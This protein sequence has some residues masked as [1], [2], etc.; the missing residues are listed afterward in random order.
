VAKQFA[1]TAPE[2]LGRAVSIWSTPPHIFK[3]L[4]AEFHF[5][6]DVCADQENKKCKHW[7]H[8]V[9]CLRRT[10]IGTCWLNPPYGKEISEYLGKAKESAVAGATVVCLVPG[11]TNAPWWH[12]HVMRAAEIRFVRKK[13]AFI[14]DDG[15]EGVP[16]WGTVIAIFRP[17]DYSGAM[18]KVCSWEQPTKH[19]NRA[20]R[21]PRKVRGG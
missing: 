20:S 11:R 8:R 12:E 4:D 6:V 21:K 2:R 9:D 19:K 18:P 13:L 7:M 1:A 3:A 15:T 16:S 17:L 10:W 14:S 5:T